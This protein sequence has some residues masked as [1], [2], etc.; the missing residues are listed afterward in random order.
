MPIYVSEGG[1]DFTPAPEGLHPAV[2]VDVVDLGVV[3]TNF[4]MKH[5]IK[6]I[7]QI[8][9]K[10]EKGER[11]QIRRQYTPSLFEGSNLRRDLESWR[12]KPFSPEQ[13]QRFDVEALIGANCQIQVAHRKSTKNRIYANVQAIVKAAPGQKLVSE[14]YTREESKPADAEPGMDEDDSDSP[15]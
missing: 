13:L 11:F 4:G 1:A 10:N 12:G 3:Q 2:C 14:N 8:A 15:F 7:W 5:Q 6:V 9:A